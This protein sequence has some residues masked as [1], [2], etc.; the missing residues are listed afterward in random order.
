MLEWQTSRV[1]TGTRPSSTAS[2]HI[3]TCPE[4]WDSGTITTAGIR[5]LMS[6]LGATYPRR[7]M[8]NTGSSVI[9][10]H[11]TCPATWGASRTTAH[12][13]PLSPVPAG[14]QEN[15]P[16]KPASS[17]AVSGA[18]SMQVWRR[19]TPASAAVLPMCPHCRGLAAP[20]VTI[21]A[22]G[23]PAR[24]AVGTGISACIARGSGPAAGTFLLHLGSCTLRIIL[25]NT[26]PAV[27]VHG[28]F[29]SRELPLWRSGFISFML[30]IQMMF[31]R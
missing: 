13:P 12:L 17:S 16:S 15:S 1:S 7:R 19:V 9:S 30:K 21:H 8:D 20:C 4:N 10:Q 27:H 23:R 2:T 5:I 24:S 25:M 14:L 28:I 31:W 29:T 6:S 26:V 22:L 11:A 3:P 18:T